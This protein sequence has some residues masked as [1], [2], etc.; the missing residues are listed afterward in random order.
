MFQYAQVLARS[1]ILTCFVLTWQRVGILTSFLM[2]A[3]T[4]HEGPTLMTS[5]NLI[6]SPN[7]PFLTVYPQ[8]MGGVP[9]YEFG[10]LLS[11]AAGFFL[12]RQV[13][14]SLPILPCVSLTVPL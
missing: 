12:F 6:A 2:R 8:H 9:I 3:L 1:A 13:P 7:A 11:L 5:L 10:G 14:L 4:P